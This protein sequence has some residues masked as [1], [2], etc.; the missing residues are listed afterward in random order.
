MAQ[1]TWLPGLLKVL[2]RVC[3]Y[4]RENRE[5]LDRFITT[6]DGQ[7]A[8]DATVTACQ[9]LEAIVEDLLPLLN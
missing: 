4:I 8:L 6:E 5:F 7:N 3:K 2:N 9:L 1:K